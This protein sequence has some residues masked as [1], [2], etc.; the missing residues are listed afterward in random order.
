MFHNDESEEMFKVT[1]SVFIV[2]LNCTGVSLLSASY[3]TTHWPSDNMYRNEAY[4]ERRTKALTFY[5]SLLDIF[6]TK[7]IFLPWRWYSFNVLSPVSLTCFLSWVLYDGCLKII[8]MDLPGLVRSIFHYKATDGDPMNHVHQRFET[9]YICKTTNTYNNCTVIS[10][11][12]IF[13]I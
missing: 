8:W 13:M 2:K 9:K 12:L 5:S 11:G 3:N 7:G 6:C 1:I 4:Y 10:W